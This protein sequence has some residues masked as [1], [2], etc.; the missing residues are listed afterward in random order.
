[1]DDRDELIRKLNRDLSF[2]REQ[3]IKLLDKVD[4]LQKLVNHRT[5]RTKADPSES[6]LAHGHSRYSIGCRC[7]ICRQAASQY[8]A[9]YRAKQK[10]S[11]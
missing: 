9:A 7:G 10:Q 11:F 5:W 3:K 2:E 1:M 4:E 6:T 8:Q